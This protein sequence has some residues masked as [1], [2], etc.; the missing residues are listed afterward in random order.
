VSKPL[1]EIKADMRPLDALRKNF[2][3]RAPSSFAYAVKQVLNDQAFATQKLARNFILP[4]LFNIRNAFVR[5]SILVNKVPRSARNPNWMMSQVGAARKWKGNS[6]KAFDGMRLQEAGGYTKDHRIFSMSA[7]GG[8]FAGMPKRRFWGK[9]AD[10]NPDKY[11]G[12]S[13]SRVI[14]M[15]RILDRRNYKGQFLV[16]GHSKIKTGVYVFGKGRQRSTRRKGLAIRNIQ[17]V[18]DLSKDRIRVKPTY[19]LKT[20]TTQAVTAQTT[21]RFYAR[22]AD[23]HLQFLVKKGL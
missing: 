15:L 21:A 19:W 3:W 14:A 10:E 11:P 1:F 16:R 17:M 2:Q 23:K 7:R 20:A 13:E 12:N 18:K 5:S 22:A 4:R 6:G 9:R 8:T